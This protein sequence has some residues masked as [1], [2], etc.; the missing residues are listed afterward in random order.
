MSEQSFSTNAHRNRGLFADYYLNEILPKQADWPSLV[1][2]GKAVLA[3]L[4]ALRATLKPEDLDESQLEDRWIKPVLK[5]LGHHYAV[6]FKIRF[7]GTAHRKPDYALLASQADA[8]A[9]TNQIYTPDDI[10]HVLAIADAKAWGVR[11]DQTADNKPSP[12]LQID[13]YLRYSERPWG[14]LTD[15]RYWRLYHRDSSKNNVYYEI[16]LDYLLNLESVLT[17]DLSDE[18][19][20]FYAFFRLEALSHGWLE[21]VRRGSEDFAER[22]SD[23]LESQVYDALEGIAQGFLEYRRNKVKPTPDTLKLIYENSLVLL[24]RLLFILYAESRDILPM[25]NTRYK[26]RSSLKN[27]TSKRIAPTDSI[28]TTAT[29][30]YLQDLFFAIDSGDRKLTM[31][32]YNGRLFSDDDHA[33]LKS[34]GVGDAYLNAALDKL[35]RIEQDGKSVSVD[36]RDLDVR[37][38]GSVYE[39]L[40]EYT[41]DIARDPLKLVTKVTGSRKQQVYEVAQPGEAVIKEAGQVYLRT[42]SNERKVTGS[43]YTPDYIV[44]FIV[45]KTVGPALDDIRQRYAGI[46]SEGLWVVHDSAALIREVLALNILDPATGSGHFV[47]DVIAYM[48][49]WLRGLGIRPADIGDEDELLYWK[50]QVASSCIYAVD[51][52]PLAVELAKLSV[53]LATLAKGKPLSFLDHHIRVG[54]SLVGTSISAIDDGE[55]TLDD[56]EK[57][58]K[59]GQK[60]AESEAQTGQMALFSDDH[61]NEGVRFAVAQMSAIEHT[62]AD[63]VQDVKRQEQL[64]ADLSERLSAWR[65]A[66]DVWTAR[67]FGVAFTA[68]DWKRVKDIASTG[69]VHPS[70]KGRLKEVAALAA[71]HR[72]FHWDLTFPEVFFDESGGRK[73]TPGFDAVIGNP[74]YVRQESIKSIKPYLQ[75]H[76]GVFDGKADLYLYFYERGIDYLKPES[77]LGYITS[78]TFMNT[79]SAKPFRRYIHEQMAFEWVVNFGENQPFKGAEMVYPTMGVMRRGQPKPTFHSL[80]VEGVLTPLQMETVLDEPVWAENLSEVT[81]MQEWRFQAPGLTDLFKKITVGRQTLG[82]KSSCEL[83]SGIKTGFNAA[84]VVDEI[85]NARLI[86]EHPSSAE[87]LKPIRH[88]ENLRPWVQSD[89]REYLIFARKGTDI[90]AYPAI[91][92]HLAK[93]RTMLEPKPSSWNDKIDGVWSGRKAGY[94]KWFEL[95]DQ[96][97]Y[98][99]KFKLP[100]IMGPDI[101][102]LPRFSWDTQSLFCNEKGFIIIPDSLSLLSILN[103]R[104]IWFIISQIAT[105]LRLR[106]DL[107]QYQAKIQFVKRLP[108]PDLTADQESELSTLAQHITDL[109]QQRYTLHEDE[110]QTLSGEFGG[111]APITSHKTLYRWWELPTVKALSAE[112]KKLFKRDIPVHK[113]TEYRKYLDGIKARHVALTEQ[114]A[115][116]EIRLNEVVYDAFGLT[117]GER[118]LI[119]EATQYPYGEV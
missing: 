12:S 31:P 78:G 63:N 35:A 76:Y 91:E 59:V 34:N 85:T 55:V 102:K 61:F 104:V 17:Q 94:Y 81:G 84:F 24:Y 110:R 60:K 74:P 67:Y 79:E 95:Q 117:A 114:I 77:R 89:G 40:L 2:E 15:G 5:A 58:R 92:R 105:P 99:E 69:E 82:E 36:Y 11:L 21:A 29:Y 51:I 13:E 9:I 47:V 87:L 49:E 18:F 3:Q 70:L 6:Q 115:A 75:R 66:A 96:I 83:Y 23:A 48:A 88:G 100:K 109:A 1:A 19:V 43:F 28:D 103:S 16:D 42:G 86:K 93:F 41:L 4:Q 65:Q 116:L 64:Y 8:D 20:Y 68:E 46:D 30:T 39:K 50:R 90:S 98:H 7:R 97:A 112:L 62:I 52:N 119:E 38:L 26:D 45:E 111:G 37:H 106:A 33:F 80:F 101:A 107:W 22:L 56:E 113:Q 32:P 14:I 72:F 73:A 71:E 44:R 54:N 53:W 57:R 25:D 27:L 10:T 118:G 108:T